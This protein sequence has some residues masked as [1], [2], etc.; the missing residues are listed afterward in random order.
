MEAIYYVSLVYLKLLIVIFPHLE[1]HSVI[2]LSLKRGCMRY[3]T[4][5]TGPYW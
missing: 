3:N 5:D 2:K 1:L 4:S